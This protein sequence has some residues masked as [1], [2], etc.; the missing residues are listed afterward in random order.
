MHP[1]RI[2]PMMKDLIQA[3]VLVFDDLEFTTCPGCPRCGGAVTGHDTRTKKFA[4]LTENE[5]ERIVRVR[6]KRFTCKSCGTLCY[7][8]E[9]FYPGT[10]IGSPVIDLFTSLSATMHASRAARIIDA[11]GISVDRTTWKNYAGMRFSGIPE[12][13]MFGMRLPVCIMM[14]SDRAARSTD[15]YQI[16]TQEILAA[17]G[18][19]SRKEITGNPPEDRI[20]DPS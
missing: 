17:C 20:G 9:P 1:P 7:A 19:P 11:M 3:A 14:L 10:R 15:K 8:D 18:F 16:D 4:T 2:S 13:D 5:N 12:M 6:V